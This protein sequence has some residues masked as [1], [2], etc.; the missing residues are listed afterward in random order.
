MKE[1]K[2]LQKLNE[3][4]EEENKRNLDKI[5]GLEKKIQT[6][7]AKKSEAPEVPSTSSDSQTLA[8]N[9]QIPCNICIY[10]ATCEEELNWHMGEDH[11]LSTE[12]YFDTDF[13]CDLCGK[14]CRSGSDL[15]YHL[16]KHEVST[17][18][19]VISCIICE[20]KFETTKNMMIHKKQHHKEQ[21][22]SCWKFTAG[23]CELGDD[24]CWFLHSEG[25]TQSII[26]DIKCNLCEKVFHNLNKFMEHKKSVHVTSVKQCKNALSKTCWYGEHK[27]WFRHDLTIIDANIESKK[28]DDIT[29]KIFKMMEKFTH[30]IIELENKIK[31][32][33]QAH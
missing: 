17:I 23:N 29:E 13:P 31:H 28:N 10:V 27:C 4:L 5:E 30:R 8:D 2:V 21:V 26:P 9:V 3:A 16:R 1:F 12:S 18:S 7:Q 20:E 32:I 15:V 24:V 22:S 33:E 11:D 6:L 25:L 14:W 19:K